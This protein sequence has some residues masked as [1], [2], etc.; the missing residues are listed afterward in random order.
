MTAGYDGRAQIHGVS[1]EVEDRSLTVVMGPNGSG[2]TTLMRVMLGLI[3]PMGGTISYPSTDGRRPNF[4]YLPQ[5]SATDRHF[6]IDVWDTVCLGLNGRKGIFG[7]INA[8]DREAVR[9]ALARMEMDKM[10]HR[11]IGE[12]SGGQLQRVLMAR[13]IVSRPDVL[14]LDEPTTYTDENTSRRMRDIIEEL[15]H[16]CAVVVV[17]HDNNLTESL[18][19]ARTLRM[20]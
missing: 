3:K 2:K 19:P 11:P 18:S 5:Y 7:R 4:G 6:P 8:A 1:L 10:A 20:G 12:L 17:S 15:R 9:H 13:A 14:I 16:E